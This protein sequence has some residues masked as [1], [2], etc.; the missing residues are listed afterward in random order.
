MGT[1]FKKNDRVIIGHKHG[2][3]G[4]VGKNYYVIYFDKPMRVCITRVFGIVVSK[5]SLGMR[6]EKKPPVLMV[7]R[8]P[9]CG[10]EAL[11]KGSKRV[12]NATICAFCQEM[13]KPRGKRELL[14]H[15]SVKFSIVPHGWQCDV[16]QK[17]KGRR[18]SKGTVCRDWGDDYHSA[19]KLLVKLTGI[20][21]KGE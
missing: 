13:K 17:V 8:C 21:E 19:Q 7:F 11:L 3:I 1:D 15:A 2:T 10:E 4:E 14:E 5:D 6:L 9:K 18:T 16:Q 12:G 20:G